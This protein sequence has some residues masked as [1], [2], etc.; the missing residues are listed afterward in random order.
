MRGKIEVVEISDF[1]VDWV[2][3]RIIRDR[4]A[5]FD[6]TR[7]EMFVITGDV[8]VRWLRRLLNVYLREGSIPSEWHSDLGMHIWKHIYDDHDVGK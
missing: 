5:G 1:E 4:A 6:E 8:G 2:L 7:V 3:R